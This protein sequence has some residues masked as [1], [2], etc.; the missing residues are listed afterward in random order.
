MLVLVLFS[1]F[2]FISALIMDNVIATPIMLIVSLI[3]LLGGMAG[4]C[5]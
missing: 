4:C 3:M 5:R 1:P 2:M